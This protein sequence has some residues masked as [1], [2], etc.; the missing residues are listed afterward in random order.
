MFPNNDPV[1]FMVAFYGCLLAELVPVPIEVPL[2]RKVRSSGHTPAARARFDRRGSLRTPAGGEEALRLC[3]PQLLS[4]PHPVHFA[5]L[6]FYITP[7]AQ[8]GLR[9]IWPLLLF[10]LA[11]DRDSCSHT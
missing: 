5:M 2:T 1:M 6:N 7:N 4:L 11:V 9:W 10:L 3:S 8:Q